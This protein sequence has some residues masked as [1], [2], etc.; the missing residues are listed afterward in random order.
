MKLICSRFNERILKS[1]RRERWKPI[2]HSIIS[3]TFSSGAQTDNAEITIRSAFELLA[4]GLSFLYLIA[5]CLA[6]KHNQGSIVDDEQRRAV[7]GSDLVR[8]LVSAGSPVGLHS[9]SFRSSVLA[10]PSR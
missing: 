4:P 9:Y 5:R 6:N 1:Y 2:L 10:H 8:V 3:Q 7:V